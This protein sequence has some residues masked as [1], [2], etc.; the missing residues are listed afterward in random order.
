MQSRAEQIFV[1]GLVARVSSEPFW[2]RG[3][4]IGNRA[5]S[6]GVPRR[7][8]AKSAAVTWHCDFDTST[9]SSSFGVLSDD[10]GFLPTVKER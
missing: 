9:S 2:I 1:A 6:G 3:A 7:S 4:S 10:D 8:R 5:S